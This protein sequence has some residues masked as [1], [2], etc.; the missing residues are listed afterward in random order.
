M[1]SHWIYCSFCMMFHILFNFVSL[2]KK[3]LNYQV[4]QCDF[5]S[6]FEDML[7]WIMLVYVF[8]FLR[9]S[10]KF[11]SSSSEFAYWFQ[12]CDFMSLWSQGG[13]VFSGGLSLWCYL[14]REA[15]LLCDSFKK[16][17][18]ILL[19]S[20][21]LLRTPVSDLHFSNIYSFSDLSTSDGP[22]FSR[23]TLINY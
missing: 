19:W 21:S 7:Y 3:F 8:Y 1:F 10:K 13:A 4:I 15:E 17:C 9:L 22:G 6:L 12:I 16:H 23:N 18:L 2:L 5:L 14:L 20:Q 11:Y